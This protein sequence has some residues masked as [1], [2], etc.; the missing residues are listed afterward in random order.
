M[1]R[2]FTLNILGLLIGFSSF[3][4]S[5]EKTL[6]IDSSFQDQGILILDEY[7][8]EIEYDQVAERISYINSSIPLSFNPKV[9][10]FCEYYAQRDRAY[11]KKLLK[12]VN[13]YFPIFE[14]YLAKHNLPDELKYLTLF[15]SGL[16]PRAKSRAGAVGLWQFMPATGR[17]LKLDQDWYIDER[18]DPEKATE[19]ACLYLK[20]L[21][22]QFGDWELALSAYNAGPGNVR[23]AIRRSGG[24]RDF[25]KI[26]PK[27]PRETRNYVPQF[28]AVNYIMN[29]LDVHNFVQDEYA[30]PLK[31]QP[32]SVSQFLNL[33]ILAKELNVCLEDL[34][35]LN[36]AMKRN[37][38]PEDAQDFTVN[39]PI[40]KYDYF[41]DYRGEILAACE[42]SGQEEL[43]KLSRN[44]PGST[45]GRTLVYHRIRSG[46][47]LGSIARRYS[48]R[49]SDLRTWN[50]IRGNMIRAGK[51][52]KVYQAP[53]HQRLGHLAVNENPDESG[54]AVVSSDKTNGSIYRVR[55]G[56]TLWSISKSNGVSVGNLKNL[57]NLR[58]NKIKVGQELRLGR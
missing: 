41:Q 16:N 23:K 9:F 53:T 57:N 45:Y 30:F 7:I 40:D 42:A 21:Y 3:G 44:A 12:R 36:P 47:V 38:V 50:N 33:E 11:V 55:R 15:E 1:Q 2:L 5:P 51:R 32:V 35:L 43:K 27:L 17:W 10:Y 31:S 56:D 52:L 29:Y 22:R 46:E 48:V 25:W 13:L 8:P 18:M 54:S 14:K 20:D 39:I 49:V 4:F 26:Y 24:L 37:A 19:A 6:P 28:V 34:E 58:S